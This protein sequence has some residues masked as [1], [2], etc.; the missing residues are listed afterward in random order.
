MT[1]IT[2][3]YAGYDLRVEAIP[4]G[5]RTPVTVTPCP[6]CQRVTSEPWYQLADSSLRVVVCPDCGLGRLWPLPPPEVIGSFY[7]QAYYGEEGSKFGSLVEFMVRWVAARRARFLARH[8]PAQG[9]ILEVGCG[10][11][12]LLGA[13]VD[14]GFEVHGVELNTQA[15]QGIDPQVHQ[16]VSA[17][18]SDLHFPEGYF[19]QVIIWHVFEH[20]PNP[21]ETIHEIRRVLRTG[22]TM[23]L[24]VPNFSSWQSRW[25]GNAWFHL[26]LPRHLFHFPIEA[27]T[28]LIND[29]GFVVTRSHHFS[30]RQNPFGW[31][32]SALNKLTRLPRNGLYVLLQRR[33]ADQPKPFDSRTRFWLML[34]WWLGMPWTVPLSILEA[35]ARR[36]ATIHVVAKAVAS[37]ND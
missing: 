21:R 5:E 26:D 1:T 25:A 12:V 18:L 22:G 17:T 14:R 30:L 37:N 35:L 19:D 13:L 9:R 27:L 32:Q 8:V 15:F 33:P 11:G 16:H 4:P 34:A 23:V 29:E 24:A 20:L 10:R 31:L 7:S 36:G 2:V 6:V 28:R 3:P